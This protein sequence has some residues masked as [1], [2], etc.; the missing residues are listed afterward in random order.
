MCKLYSLW[1]ICKM[2]WSL[3]LASLVILFLVMPCGNVLADETSEAGKS[4]SE[5]KTTAGDGALGAGLEE[6][7]KRHKPGAN[8]QSTTSETSAKAPSP[9]YVTSRELGVDSQFTCGDL[10]DSSS[11]LG[12]L[13]HCGS[14][15]QI[16]V[17]ADVVSADGEGYLASE[18]VRVDT[19]S[20]TASEELLGFECQQRGGESS[21]MRPTP[22]SSP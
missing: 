7:K 12:G 6:T 22:S 18:T 8:N 15:N 4:T 13:L 5:L 20:G 9:V 3:V 19:R 11:D 14:A 16:C 21:S 10:H 2:Q 17:A 1:P